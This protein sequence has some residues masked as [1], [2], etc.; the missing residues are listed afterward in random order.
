MFIEQVFKLFFT[1]CPIERFLFLHPNTRIA[2]TT[3]IKRNTWP[4]GH[5]EAVT[6]PA[7]RGVVTI[8]HQQYPD[9]SK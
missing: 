6:A 8:F 9:F 4:R 3:L 1:R 5:A 7:K 2:P